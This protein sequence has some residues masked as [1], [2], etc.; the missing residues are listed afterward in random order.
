MIE[1]LR[2]RYARWRLRHP[3]YFFHHL[4]KCGGTSVREAL[5]NWF[6]VNDDY[7][8]EDGATTLPPIDLKNLNRTNCISGHFGHE[9]YYIEQRYPQ[10][11]HGFKASQ[12][13]RAFMF[14][15]DPLEMRCSLYRHEVKAGKAQHPD[16]ATAI[17]PF[18][19]FYSRIINVNEHN[20]KQR[21]DQYFFVGIADDLQLSFDLLADLAGKRRVKLPTSNTTTLAHSN[22][23]HSL[24]DEEREA[25][26]IANS[27][28]YQIFDYAKA[29]LIHLNLA[30]KQD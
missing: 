3:I 23:M 29:K 1:N 17:M 2:H 6:S 24:S 19:N 5:E 28:D 11:F 8:D 9:G 30:G 27:L 21:I 7:F 26:K 14:L 16:L 13:Y 18:S 25:F 4:P 12:R 15:R 22:S 10:I 20:W